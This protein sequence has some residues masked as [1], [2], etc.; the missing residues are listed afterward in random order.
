MAVRKYAFLGLLTSLLGLSLMPT[1]KTWAA[2]DWQLVN[3]RLAN[4][5]ADHINAFGFVHDAH[6]TID[7]AFTDWDA[8]NLKAQFDVQ[9]VDLFLLSTPDPQNIQLNGDFQLQTQDLGLQ[10]EITAHAEISISGN[11]VFLL[12]H[13]NELIADCSVYDA[14]ELF[15]VHFCAYSDIVAQS[16]D[17]STYQPALEELKKAIL[18][19][20]PAQGSPVLPQ[21]SWVDEVF[22][23]LLNSKISGDEISVS[24]FADIDLNSVFNLPIM[25]NAELKIT[26]KDISIL[27]NGSALI[28]NS[29]YEAYKNTIESALVAFQN[30]DQDTMAGLYQYSFLI[31]GLIEG[32]LN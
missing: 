28:N 7:E 15:M 13:L 14:T 10:K 17:V 22:N 11:I 31:F 24:L 23:V 18:T 4:V 5:A 8:G 1:Q 21:K 27:L 20:S 29:D 12:R 3:H 16:D 2:P 9:S 19:F 25:A 30:G 32:F 6:A 26:S